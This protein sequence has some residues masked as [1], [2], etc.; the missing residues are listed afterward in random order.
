MKKFGPELLSRLNPRPYWWRYVLTYVALF[1]GS[2]LAKINVR[3]R[4]NLPKKPPFVVA[5]NHFSDHD[6][7]FFSYALRKP[8]NFIAASDQ[9]IEIAFIWAP[10]IYG[11]IPVDRKNLSPST[12]KKAVKALRNKEILGIFPDGGVN[13]N[14]LSKPKNGAVFLSTVGKCPIVPMSIY[15][16]ERSWEGLLKGIR[17]RVQINIG[18]SFGPYELRG[19]KDQK[20]KKMK[21]VGLEMMG[22]IASLLPENRRGSFTD[23]ESI[24]KYQK[25]NKVVPPQCFDFKPKK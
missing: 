13:Y 15:G 12:I 7:L 10:V 6:P 5:C 20:N 8:I 18:K 17:S 21:K 11:W 4:H 22:R 25:E 2:T 9:E 3:G 19:D 24:L 14:L 23:D 1:M 16:A